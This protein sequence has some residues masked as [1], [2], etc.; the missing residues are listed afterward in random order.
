[1]VTSVEVLGSDEQVVQVAPR[2]GPGVPGFGARY[3]ARRDALDLGVVV[4]VVEEDQRLTAAGGRL[5]GR[6]VHDPVQ[7]RD[8]DVVRPTGHQVADVD[9][10]TP[11]EDGNVAPLPLRVADLEATWGVLGREDGEASVI[12]VGA[13]A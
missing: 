9:D 2:G 4:R 8:P 10:E 3:Q 1:M 7:G 6:R 13:G 5:L 12:R 11:R